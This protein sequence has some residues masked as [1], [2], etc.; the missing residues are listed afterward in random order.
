MESALPLDPPTSYGLD[1]IK[2]KINALDLEHIAF[3][4][5]GVDLGYVPLSLC[6]ALADGTVWPTRCDG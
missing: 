2:V 5:D 3:I 6:A 4:L 1:D